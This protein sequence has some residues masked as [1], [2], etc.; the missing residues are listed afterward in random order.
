M[1]HMKNAIIDIWMESQN[2]R[3]SDEVHMIEVEVLHR[4]KADGLLSWLEDGTQTKLTML[5]VC[6]WFRRTPNFR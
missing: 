1:K 4:L 6:F 5:Q 3:I 2:F